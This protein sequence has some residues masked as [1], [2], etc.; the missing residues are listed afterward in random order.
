MGKPPAIVA[1]YYCGL[2][3]FKEYICLE[4]P[5]YASKKSREWWRQRSPHPPPETTLAALGRLGELSVPARIRV[6]IDL[7][8][9][10]IKG[11]EYD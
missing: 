9:P 2:R 10:E 11:V 6:Q 5:G 1:Q 7:A 3:M 8:H 4:H